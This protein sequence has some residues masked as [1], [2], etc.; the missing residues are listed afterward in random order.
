M[1][2][3]LRYAGMISSVNFANGSIKLNGSATVS[4]IWFGRLLILPHERRD[5]AMRVLLVEDEL[6]GRKKY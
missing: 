5:V 6:L 3:K 4:I 2:Q 1:P